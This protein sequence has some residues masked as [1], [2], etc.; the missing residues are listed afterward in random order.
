MPP[1]T[2]R[3]EEPV[4]SPD[5]YPTLLGVAGLPAVPEQHND[6]VDFTPLLRGEKFDRGP[7]Y[8]HYPHYSNQGGTPSAG[9]RDGRWKLIYRFET[10]D[11]K[12]FDLV[13]D[14]SENHDLAQVEVDTTN[15][16]RG[17]LLSWLDTVA[18]PRPKPNPHREPFTGLAG[19]Y[20]GGRV[21]EPPSY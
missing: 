1:S 5:I 14:I 13:D 16:M 4:T 11:C 9:M 6:G 7:I 19:Y 12:L 3:I 10:D 17:V 8:W 2:S 20:L 15:R 18:T 21:T